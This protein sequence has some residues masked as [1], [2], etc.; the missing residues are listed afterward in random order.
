MSASCLFLV[1]LL[2]GPQAPVPAQGP[3]P[4]GVLDEARKARAAGDVPE[5]RR[6]YEQALSRDPRNPNLALE[7]AEALLDANDPAAA[8]RILAVLVAAEPDRPGP[9]RALARSLLAR[10]K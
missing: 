9:R 4:A 10:G 2:A 8:G 6:L 5:T 7:F 1:L 3:P